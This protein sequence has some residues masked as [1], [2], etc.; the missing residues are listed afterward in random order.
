MQ[1]RLVV[2]DKDIAHVTY[3]RM[4]GPP[5]ESEPERKG[6][7]KTNPKELSWQRCSRGGSW[8]VGKGVC[9][10]ENDRKTNTRSFN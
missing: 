7:V 8:K 1:N 5:A 10:V 9:R 4:D 6:H 3:E 2:S